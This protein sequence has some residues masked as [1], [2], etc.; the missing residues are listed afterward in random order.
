MKVG[1][2]EPLNDAV[3]AVEPSFAVATSPV[4][5]NVR[6]VRNAVA[7]FTVIDRLFV[8][9]LPSIEIEPVVSPPRVIVRAVVHFDA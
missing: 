1:S 3:T 8:A 4:I 2:A 7:V 9:L 5:V 6:D